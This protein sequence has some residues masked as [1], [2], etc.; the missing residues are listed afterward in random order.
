MAGQN[1]ESEGFGVAPLQHIP[2]GGEVSERLGHLLAL[3]IEKAGVHPV[4]HQRLFSRRCLHLGD[5]CLVVRE[6]EVHRSAMDII[7]RSKIGLGDRRVL[8]M[9]SGPTQSPG[10]VPGNFHSVLPLLPER[11]VSRI[12]LRWIRL[13]PVLLQILSV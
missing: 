12:S 4:S 1:K 3:N 7:L 13:D 6:Y 2:N 10:R 11:E 5:L 9:P 8:D